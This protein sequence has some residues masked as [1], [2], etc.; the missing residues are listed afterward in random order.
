MLLYP[1]FRPNAH[2]TSERRNADAGD[3]NGPRART[4]NPGNDFVRT[5]LAE[6]LRSWMSISLSINQARAASVLLW[7]A[8]SVITKK[9]SGAMKER[10]TVRQV[11]T[12]LC[13]LGLLSRWS[14]RAV[15]A[16]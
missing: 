10:N 1:L 3:P 6:C 7:L 15:A 14:Y 2:R 8:G 11:F 4:T 9:Q 5:I 16:Q 12:V 13:R